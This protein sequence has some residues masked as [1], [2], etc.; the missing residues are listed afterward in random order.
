M[1]IIDAQIFFDFYEIDSDKSRPSKALL[2]DFLV[3]SLNI[4]ITDELFNEIDRHKILE[5]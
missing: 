1:C 5:H 3:D 2:S 4:C